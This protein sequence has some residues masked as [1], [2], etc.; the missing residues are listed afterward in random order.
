MLRSIL[1]QRLR[2]L[3]RLCGLC[4]S[5][6]LVGDVLRGVFTG[7][8]LRG[9]VRFYKVYSRGSRNG[10]LC[11][12]LGGVLPDGGSFRGCGVCLPSDEGKVCRELLAGLREGY[13]ALIL[14]SACNY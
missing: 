7:S 11:D 4:G 5:L 13:A 1:R 3:R 9:S 6:R 10:L 12:M 2:R 14:E 8:F